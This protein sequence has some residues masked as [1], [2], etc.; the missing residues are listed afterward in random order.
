MTEKHLELH[1]KDGV[2][3][4]YLYIPDGPGPHPG[5]IHLTDIRGLRESHQA[6]AARLAEQGYV[7]LMPN[8]FYRTAK[9]PIFTFPMNMQEERTKKWFAELV[10]PLTPEKMMQDASEY[11]DYL[12]SLPDVSQGPMGV[13]GYCFAGQIA[14]RTAVARPDRVAAAAS[15]HGGGLL[16]AAPTSPHLAIP[17]VK[18]RLYFGHAMEDGSMPA[19]A[20]E[21]FEAALAAWGGRYE[22][23]TYKA[24][25]GWTV[26]DSPVYDQPEAERAFPKLAALM[27]ETLR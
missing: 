19:E 5:V 13:V 10:G 3:D 22:S 24:R 2:T 9:P 18:A 23:E 25:H 8:L 21:K 4:A 16:T 6:M 12:A 1:L 27:A 15:F 20:I 26:A 7:V 14:L 17:Q 11:V